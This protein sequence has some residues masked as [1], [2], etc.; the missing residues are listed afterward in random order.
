[1]RIWQ[2]ADPRHSEFSQPRDVHLKPVCYLCTLHHRSTTHIWYRGLKE[3]KS[4]GFK[5][6]SRWYV[7]VF[8]EGIGSRKKFCQDVLGWS[9]CLVDILGVWD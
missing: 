9:E 3:V 6:V 7:D 5:V 1:M 4:L 8:S 2:A